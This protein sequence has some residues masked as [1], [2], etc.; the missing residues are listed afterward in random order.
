[1]CLKFLYLTHMFNTLMTVGLKPTM[2]VEHT[3]LND[4]SP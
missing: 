4:K 3:L 1:L 2:T